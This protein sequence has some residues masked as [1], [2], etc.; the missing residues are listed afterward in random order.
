VACELQSSERRDI[1]I[2]QIYGK[3]VQTGIEAAPK[4]FW[5]VP[6]RFPTLYKGKSIVNGHTGV[7]DSFL[8]AVVA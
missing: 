1:Y 4:A 2:F 5:A 3:R 7:R 6:V 8:E